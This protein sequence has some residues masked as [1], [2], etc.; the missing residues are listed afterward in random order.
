RR[1]LL[2]E[3]RTCCHPGNH[4]PSAQSPSHLS[5]Q[6]CALAAVPREPCTGN[7]AKKPEP[8]D[9]LYCSEIP[10][11]QSRGQQALGAARTKQCPGERPKDLL[12]RVPRAR[13]RHLVL[14]VPRPEHDARTILD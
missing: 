3:T 4:E 10:A 5:R 14:A 8:Q 9:P 13:T 1:F 12:D 2:H 6:A 11:K 7:T